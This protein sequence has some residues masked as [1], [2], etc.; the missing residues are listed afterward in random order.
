MICLVL[1]FAAYLIGF[2]VFP[3]KFC[4]SRKYFGELNASQQVC[5]LFCHNAVLGREVF[6]CLF[7]G[8]CEDEIDKE[9]KKT[10]S[11]KAQ[12]QRDA[13]IKHGNQVGHRRYHCSQK[14]S[15]A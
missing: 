5:Q 6:S 4:T 3:A 11:N 14:S 15:E 10:E 1:S 12:S 7:H 13:E 2:L 8:L 9:G